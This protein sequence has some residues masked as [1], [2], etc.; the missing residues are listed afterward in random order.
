[1][2]ST[3]FFTEYYKTVRTSMKKLQESLQLVNSIPNESLRIEIAEAIRNR[4][5][6]YEEGYTT[7][8][9][10]IDMDLLNLYHGID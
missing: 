6:I 4:I 10:Y 5:S 1:M 3:T 8:E 7:L 9:D 2:E